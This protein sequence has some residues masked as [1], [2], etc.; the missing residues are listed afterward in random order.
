MV[1]F[2]F[3]FHHILR[4]RFCDPRLDN[5]YSCLNDKQYNNFVRFDLKSIQQDCRIEDCLKLNF[6]IY[7][8]FH[9]I[10]PLR[11][12]I[13]IHI[14]K[15]EYCEYLHTFLYKNCKLYQK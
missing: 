12:N 14:A 6:L 7:S 15:T 11:N 10:R 2:D 13:Q 1:L 8:V 5:H 3:D 4:E 9:M